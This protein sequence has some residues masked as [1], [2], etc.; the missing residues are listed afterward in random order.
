MKR[1]LV[2][3]VDRDD[4]I[5]KVGVKTPIVGDDAILEA[6]R[7]FGIRYP[8]DPDLNVMF[9]AVET[10]EKLRREG[11]EAITA[12]VA[13]DPLDPVK[14]DLRIRKQVEELVHEY[15]VD[16]I[17]LV[18]DGREDEEV[19]PAISGVAPVV[20]VR[21]VIVE[22][23]RGI[24]DMYILLGRYIKKAI[25]EP[26][27]ARV[28]LGY[29]GIILAG[30]AILALLGLLRYAFT[31]LV[32]VAGV[33]MMIR[34]F[35]LE[36]RILEVWSKNQIM[37]LATLVAVVSI[38]AAGGIAYYTIESAAGQPVHYVIA[39]VLAS[40]TPLLGLA[41]ISIIAARIAS[42]LVSGKLLIIN[43]LADLAL[44][45]IIVIMA[46][47]LS[48]TLHS[49]SPNPTPP[50]IAVSIVTSGV[51]ITALTGIAVI[52]VIRFLAGYLMHRSASPSGKS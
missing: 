31:M 17:V 20:S 50:E 1:I 38:A 13:G 51:L 42:K 26:R 33:L 45:M 46:Y 3:A 47:Q 8:E 41:S 2:L 6:A 25:V 49:L 35:G 48:A 28:F 23:A 29:P 44:A 43:E 9:A 7:V 10:A 18:A 19:I 12:L 40:I 11:V 16:G 21:R 15:R 14:A 32:L 34:G 22:Q 24:E 27:F 37:V 4:D 36:E 30:F 5:G 39:E 52:A